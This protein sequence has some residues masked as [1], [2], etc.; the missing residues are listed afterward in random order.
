MEVDVKSLVVRSKEELEQFLRELQYIPSVYDGTDSVPPGNVGDALYYHL[1]EI[2]ISSFDD[3]LGLRTKDPDLMSWFRE[4]TE[5]MN[6]KMV[7]I[8]ETWEL[9]QK[10]SW[11]DGDGEVQGQEDPDGNEGDSSVPVSGV[12][13]DRQA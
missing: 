5:K 2:A 7:Q 4:Q 3:V 6:K 9:W 10:H 8:E 1:M 11:R 13:S 12:R